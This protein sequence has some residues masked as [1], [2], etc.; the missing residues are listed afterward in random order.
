MRQRALNHKNQTLKI[1]KY[2]L[3]LIAALSPQAHE[4]YQGD[5]YPS[6]S[7]ADSFFVVTYSNWKTPPLS[8]IPVGTTISP[9]LF[10]DSYTFSGYPQKKVYS[11]LVLIC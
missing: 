6:V 4:D 8:Q 10:A 2:V 5:I 7:I 3:L 11:F 9:T 1:A